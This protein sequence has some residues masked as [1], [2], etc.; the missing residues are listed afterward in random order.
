MWGK[1]WVVAALSVSSIAFAVP[2]HADQYDYVNV[3]DNKGVYYSSISDVI[4]IGKLTCS[5]LRAGSPQTAGAPA[6]AAGYSSYEVGIIVVAATNNMCPDQLPT[7]Q[8]FI[9]TPTSPPSPQAAPSSGGAALNVS[10]PMSHPAC[11]GTG[12]VMLGS[13]TTPGQYAEGVQQLLNANPGASYLRTD[14]S[15]LSTAG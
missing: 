10:T 11:D 15:C 4:D 2:A 9:D 5:R 14:Q 6:T 7:L 3:L 1:I 8:A 13:V 12:I